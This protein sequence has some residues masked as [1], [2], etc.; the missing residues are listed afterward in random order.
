MTAADKQGSIIYT[1]APSITVIPSDPFGE[2]A[3][4]EEGYK[5]SEV[6]GSG[7]LTL[8]STDRTVFRIY[9]GHLFAAR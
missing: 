8:V 1:A 5:A 9:S 7:D 6:W 3:P 4:L 2:Q